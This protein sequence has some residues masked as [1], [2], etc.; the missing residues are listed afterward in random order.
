MIHPNIAG[1]IIDHYLRKP[2]GQELVVGT[3]LGT[4]DGSQVDICSCFAVPQYYENES[5]IIDSDYMQKMMKFHRKVNPK[6][7]LVGM[8]ISQRVLDEHGMSLI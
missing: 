8:Y 4:V 5:L 6:E 1:N 3:L 7:G 2:E